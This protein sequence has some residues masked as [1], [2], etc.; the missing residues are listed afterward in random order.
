MVGGLRWMLAIKPVTDQWLKDKR[1][2]GLSSEE[3]VKQSEDECQYFSAEQ[4]AYIREKVG[5][6]KE[7]VS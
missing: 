3:I 4:K 7:N 2:Q 5:G 6:G 1:E